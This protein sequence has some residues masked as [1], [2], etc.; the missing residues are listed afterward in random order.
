MR[1]LSHFSLFEEWCCPY[2]TGDSALC[3]GCKV[4]V[5]PERSP[6]GCHE[7]PPARCRLLAS[8]LIAIFSLSFP[9]SLSLPRWP[10]WTELVAHC[11]WRRRCGGGMAESLWGVEGGTLFDGISHQQVQTGCRKVILLF[12]GVS[13]HLLNCYLKKKNCTL[14][15]KL[16]AWPPS[17]WT[18]RA[19]QDKRWAVRSVLRCWTIWCALWM[20]LEDS[21]SGFFLFFGLGSPPTRGNALS[22]AL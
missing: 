4:T 12:M 11:E 3:T 15:W 5:R 21:L 7:S 19:E 2:F 9:L 14:R 6:L 16:W 17:G 8:D 10:S 20:N 1:F 22:T 18:F 13:D